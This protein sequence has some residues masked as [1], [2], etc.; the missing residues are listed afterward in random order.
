MGLAGQ[1][2]LNLVIKY[3]AE[4]LFREES[5]DEQGHAAVPA[6]GPLGGGGE[7]EKVLGTCILSSFLF[8]YLRFSLLSLYSYLVHCFA[9]VKFHF[10]LIFLFFLWGGMVGV[11]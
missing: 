1:E 9:V 3:G 5:D 10:L 2:Q 4:D 6:A 8:Y 11:F 7:G